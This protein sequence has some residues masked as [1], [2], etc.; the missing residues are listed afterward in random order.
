MAIEQWSKLWISAPDFDLFRDLNEKGHTHLDKDANCCLDIESLCPDAVQAFAEWYVSNNFDAFHYPKGA[1]K[2]ERIEIAREDFRNV[3]IQS[4][5][6][7][8]DVYLYA[9]IRESLVAISKLY[10]DTVLQYYG[11]NLSDDT[12]KGGDVKSGYV[13]N[14]ETITTDNRKYVDYFCFSK[15]SFKQSS[16][17]SAHVNVP[18]ILDGKTESEFVRFEVSP[19]NVVEAA[20]LGLVDKDAG[21]YEKRYAVLF[22]ESNPN[23]T[24]ATMDGESVSMTLRMLR[25][26]NNEALREYAKKMAVVDI[27]FNNND[28]RTFVGKDN[29]RLYEVSFSVPNDISENGIVKMYFGEHS[30]ETAHSGYKLHTEKN[31]EKNVRVIKYGHVESLKMKISDIRDKYNEHLGRAVEAENEEERDDI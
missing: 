14:G 27:V 29:E 4:G 11:Y 13:K 30:L 10:P 20:T 5:G 24:V 3:P 18:V 2:E 17:G 25:K 21:F 22:E 28:V 7:Y 12:I 8:G 9:G 26:I 15:N 1:T 16:N 23:V 31:F 19:E 6:D